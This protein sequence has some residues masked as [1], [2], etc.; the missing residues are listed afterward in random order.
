MNAPLVS[1][2]GDSISLNNAIVKFIIVW[3]R[4]ILNTKYD[5][6]N[7]KNTQK[8]VTFYTHDSY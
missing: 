8:R 2:R 1:Q 3:E 4:H 6:I 7:A 5:S